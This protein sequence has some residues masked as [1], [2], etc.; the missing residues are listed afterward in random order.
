[1]CWSDGRGIN[2]RLPINLTSTLCCHPAGA[3]M[4]LCRYSKTTTILVHAHFYTAKQMDEED[5]Y[6][7]PWRHTW[8]EV[9]V[10]KLCLEKRWR[11]S[12]LPALASVVVPWESTGILRIYQEIRS[13]CFSV[14]IGIESSSF[15]TVW[16]VHKWNV[17]E[18]LAIIKSCFRQTWLLINWEPE[19]VTSCAICI[20][21]KPES[22]K[23]VSPHVNYMYECF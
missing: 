5:C 19:F 11:F 23:R 4:K 3:L 21:S 20:P 8:C 17:Y 9:L 14:G 2:R 15:N 18:V 6:I 12:C 7:L 10:L 13:T 22:C 1:M 16:I